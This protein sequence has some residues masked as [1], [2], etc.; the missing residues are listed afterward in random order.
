[1]P[2][3][4][5]GGSVSDQTYQSRN[6]ESGSERAD[7]NQGCWSLVWFTTRSTMTR[8]PRS[9]ASCIISPKS[10][11]LPSRWCTL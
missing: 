1:M 4:R 9:P 10:P 5:S 6:G 8:I 11:R 2:W 3:K 7:W